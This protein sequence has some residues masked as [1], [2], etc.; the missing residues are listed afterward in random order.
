MEIHRRSGSVKYAI[1]MFVRHAKSNAVGIITNWDMP[2]KEW[3]PIAASEKLQTGR[4]QNGMDGQ[5]FYLVTGPD[6][7]G[8]YL[9]EGI[10][11]ERWNA[12]RIRDCL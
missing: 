9:A 5:P 12:I 4:G 1:G 6:G 2:R 8:R 10:H 3:Y 11:F 7:L